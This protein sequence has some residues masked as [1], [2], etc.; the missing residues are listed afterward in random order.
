MLGPNEQCKL[1]R[2]DLACV[3]VGFTRIR[4][5]YVTVMGNGF[6]TRVLSH[7]FVNLYFTFAALK[8][9]LCPQ[10]FSWHRHA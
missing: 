9:L 2:A 4:Q 5:K 7:H 6:Q 1:D 8:S 10:S 3:K